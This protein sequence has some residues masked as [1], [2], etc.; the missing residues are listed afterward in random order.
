MNRH[1]FTLVEVIVSAVILAATVAC[2]LCVFS[3]ES[4]V[5]DRTGRRMQAMV[6]ARQTLEELKN[7]VGAD[8]WP[9]SGLLGTVGVG[10][11][12]TLPGS[13]LKSK[14]SGTRTYTVTNIDADGVGGYEDDEYKQVTVTIDWTEPTE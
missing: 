10:I 9:N 11:T 12:A 2:L 6:F 7:A 8:T 3:T 1:G 13:E 4:G 14:F 5:V